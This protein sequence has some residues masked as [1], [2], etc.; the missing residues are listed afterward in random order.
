MKMTVALDVEEFLHDP[1][2]LPVW[3]TL[4]SEM[5]SVRVLIVAHDGELPLV[6]S[7]HQYDAITGVNVS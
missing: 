6:R 2:L 5:I 1:V 3:K 4:L 7:L